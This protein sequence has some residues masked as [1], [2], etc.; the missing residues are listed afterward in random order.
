MYKNQI[1]FH[2]ECYLTS[3]AEEKNIFKNIKK[4]KRERRKGKIESVIDIVL[5]SPFFHSPFSPK[6]IFIIDK[7]KEKRKNRLTLAYNGLVS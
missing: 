5:E 1:Y 2:H 4:N 6:K 7:R 3:I